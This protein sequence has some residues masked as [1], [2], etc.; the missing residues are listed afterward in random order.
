MKWTFGHG[1]E[2]QTPKPEG[3][4]KDEKINDPLTQDVDAPRRPFEKD[5]DA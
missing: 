4:A 1:L 3:D 5:K 2:R